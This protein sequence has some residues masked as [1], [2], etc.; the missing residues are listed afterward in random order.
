MVLDKEE[1]C[2]HFFNVY[3]HSLLELVSSSTVKCRL[4]FFFEQNFCI[5]RKHY[6]F[7][8]L[9]FNPKISYVMQFS[10]STLNQS[11]FKIFLGNSKLNIVNSMCLGF[12]LNY[13][14]CN[15][16]DIIRERNKSYNSFNS[17]LIKFY[18]VSIDGFLTF[19][20]S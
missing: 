19:F 20:K 7:S 5:C 15:K 14:L 2:N 9:S 18:N 1:F 10:Q 13:N 17:I 11:K 3:I 6:N 4:G 8:K 16:L 12:E